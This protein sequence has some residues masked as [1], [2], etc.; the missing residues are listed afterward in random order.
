MTSDAASRDHYAFR[1]LEAPRVPDAGGAGRVRSPV[2]A[3]VRA[4]LEQRGLDFSRDADAPTAVRRLYLDLIGLP[5]PPEEVDA[6]LQDDSPDAFLRLTDRLLASP[7]FGE[8][9]GRHWLDGAGYTDVYGGDNDAGIIKLGEN[10][11]QYRDYAVRAL[12]EDRPFDTFLLEQLAGDELCEWRTAPELTPEIRERLI[13]T[14]FLRNAADDTNENELN[15][16]DIRHGVLERTIEGV[17]SNLLGLTLSCAKCHDHKYE[18][19]PQRDYYRLKAIFQPAFNPDHWLQPQDRQLAALPPAE[20]AEALS[21]NAGLDREIGEARARIE[22]AK[23]A[24]TPEAAAAIAQEE[25]KIAELTGKKRS[26]PHWQVVYDVALP[27]PTRILTRGSPWAPAEEVEPGFPGVLC[28]GSQGAACQA[29]AQGAT[30][31]RRTSLA[32]WLTDP[33]TPAGAL[34]IRVRV[35]RIWQH[36]FGT[37]IVETADNFGWTGAPPTHPELLEWLASELVAGGGRLKPFLRCILASTAYRQASDGAGASAAASAD[38]ENR[39][40]WRQRLRRLE[41]EAIRDSILAASGRLV[42]TIGGPPTPVEPRPDGSFVVKEDGDPAAASPFRRS[43]YLLSRRNYHPTILAAFDQPH[44]TGTCARR[45]PSAVVL[46]SLTMWNDS[47]V[48]GQA[49][50]AAAREGA[51]AGSSAEQAALAFRTVLGRAPRPPELAACVEALERDAELLRPAGSAS[52]SED[53][54]RQALE[55]LYHTLFNTSELVYIP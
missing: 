46:Q 55:R 23:A 16:L 49:E 37:G 50:A 43:L 13:A 41:S 15:T 7:H 31:G 38:P 54:R 36:L 48:V 27:T 2:D 4:P 1:R 44:F 5:P 25:K 34:V 35:N 6:Y 10:K 19:I 39:L 22:A 12:N 26:W 52:S 30:S 32:R 29:A 47:F 8:R 9:W 14:G 3:F 42:R 28:T 17:A 21:W 40:L 11:W 24:S 18:P 53:A 20:K 51:A 33:R 45:S